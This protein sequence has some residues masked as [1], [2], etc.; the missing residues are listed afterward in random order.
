MFKVGDKV[1]IKPEWQ[2]PGDDEFVWIVVE[3]ED[4]GRVAIQVQLGLPINPWE[5]VDVSMIERAD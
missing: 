2:D 5:R 4:R 1:R 3:D